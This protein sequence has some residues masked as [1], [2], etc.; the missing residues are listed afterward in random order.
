MR[1][2]E[3][4]LTKADWD[5]FEAIWA[6]DLETPLCYDMLYHYYSSNSVRKV[7][8]KDSIVLR[9]SAVANFDDKMEGEA[10]RVYYDLALEELLDEG[11]I[12]DKLFEKLADVDIPDKIPFISVN[13]T[14]WSVYK[15]ES[16]EEYVICFSTVKDDPFMYEEYIHDS[17]G[18]CLHLFGGEIEALNTLSMANHANIVLI[19]ILYGK[20]AVVYIKKIILEVL[21][22][23]AKERNYK[24]FIKDLLHYVQFAA[25]R[26]KYSKEHE[27]RLVI[28]LP[29]SHPSSLPN[30][31]FSSDSKGRKYIYFSVPKYLLYDVSPAPY[32]AQSETQAIRE[33]LKRQ[34]YPNM[35]EADRS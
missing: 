26:K 24:Y 15:E 16:Y 22:D 30:I 1:N 10:V 4:Q 11:A 9:L 29:K 19:P 35:L 21:S 17:D 14:G 31:T 23:P 7:L 2:N 25:K 8:K 18:Y 13:D 32:N 12:T 3:H 33:F 20:E 27:V 6:W 5:A 34:G 28:F